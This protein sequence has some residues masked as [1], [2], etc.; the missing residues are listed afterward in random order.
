MSGLNLLGGLA[1]G[2]TQGLNNTA[3]IQNN[4]IRQQESNARLAMLQDE[5]NWR[6]KQQ[7]AAEE[8]R[9]RVGM[10][11]KISQEELLSYQEETGKQDLDRF[12]LAE[13]QA[14]ASKKA[15]QSGFLPATEYTKAAEI[16]RQLRESGVADLYMKTA[17]NDDWD[18][19][20]KRFSQMFG[21][22]TAKPMGDDILITTPDGRQTPVSRIGF[23]SL[24]K[25]D[26][27]ASAQKSAL[28]GQKARAEVDKIA[29]EA[30]EN[31]A[32]A[33]KLRT[34]AR[35]AGSAAGKSA[36]ANVQ[37]AEWYSRATP[38]QRS[39]FDRINK[40]ERAPDVA[41]AATTIFTEAKKAGELITIDEARR[42]ARQ[43]VG[44][45]DV[46]DEVKPV[47]GKDGIAEPKSAAERAA[48]PSGTRY[49]SPDGKI[50]IVP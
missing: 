4:R 43:L 42:Q 5:H 17:I 32:N 6:A 39:I 19:F 3:A 29:S 49:R 44:V 11:E 25:L 45:E 31:R 15:F 2:I 18:A 22:A 36:P 40:I 46:P 13:V 34:E 37:A 14:R 26:L 21:G 24:L 35:Y 41:K 8:E 33:W 23:E 48:L 38:E 7:Q 12:D 27:T 1:Q 20:N 9:Q 30:E 50:R 47:I 28:D 16:Q 10:L